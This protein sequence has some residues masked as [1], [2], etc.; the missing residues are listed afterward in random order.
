MLKCHG[1]V[2]RTGLSTRVAHLIRKDARRRT[3]DLISL[4]PVVPGRKDQRAVAENVDLTR[5]RA[6]PRQVR[7]PFPT[8]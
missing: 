1:V 4:E 6:A 2:V 3:T 7:S 5:S 8:Y